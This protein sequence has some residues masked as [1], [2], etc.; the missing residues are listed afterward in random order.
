MLVTYSWPGNIRELENVIHF[1]LLVSGDREIRPEHL[2]V[3]GGGW[4]KRD[5]QQVGVTGL[6]ERTHERENT[7]TDPMQVIAQQLS[8]LFAGP[9]RPHFDNLEELIVSAAFKH[10][11]GNQVHTAA[12]LGVSRNVVRTLLKRHD[13]LTNEHSE[14][15]VTGFLQEVQSC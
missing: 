15:G 12:L 6:S 5:H 9:E 14:N 2:K 4:D 10:A 11:H 13:F 1:A 7:T 3:E 8:K